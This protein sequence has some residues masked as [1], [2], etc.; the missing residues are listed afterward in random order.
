[1]DINDAILYALDKHKNQKR[2]DGTAYIMHPL[3]VALQLKN[4]GYS[5]DYQITGIFH[6]LL[7]DTDALEEEILNLSSKEVLT[8]VKLLTKNISEDSEEEYIQK[9]L[10]NEIAKVVKN[11][12]RIHNLTDAINANPGFIKRYLEDTKK[13]YLGKF[14]PELDDAYNKLSDYYS[15]YYKYEY[16]IDSSLGDISPVYRQNKAGD[17]MVYLK[18]QRK[19][20]VVDSFL[21]ADL[22]DNATI[23]SEIEAKERIQ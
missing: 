7:E 10:C 3:A 15:N 13:Y 23:I 5:L 9:I 8:S 11:E 21:W 14:S 18:K 17:I 12:D 6:D 22:G 16:F 2:K 19:W 20:N 1:M 4:K